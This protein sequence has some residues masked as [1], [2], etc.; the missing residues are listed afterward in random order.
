M[1]ALRPA[2]AALVCVLAAAATAPAAVAAPHIAKVRCYAGCISSRTVQPGGRVELVGK[3]FHTGMRAT[4]PVRTTDGSVA[5]RSTKTR[6]THSGDLIARVPSQGRSGRMFVRR[7]NGPRSNLVKVKVANPAA[8]PLP[9]TTAFDRDG[10]WI[11]YVKDASGGSA[12]AIIE[13]ARAHRIGTV[14]VKSG[15]DRNYW[16]QF[17]PKLVA[18]LKAGGLNVCG[19]QY[20]YGRH[21]KDEAKVA[22]RAIDAGADCFVIDAE[23]E[24]EGR[25]TQ[26]A[27]YVRRLRAAAGAAYP[28]ALASFPYVDYHPGFPYS[29][30]L[31][32]GGA[33]YNLPQAYWKDIGG[34]V[35]TILDHTYLWNRPYGAPVHPV[36]QLYQAPRRGEILRFRKFS[37]AAG[38]TGVSWW[39]WPEAS[40]SEWDAVGKELGPF[41]GTPQTEFA[42]LERGA[43]GD[44]VLWA[45]QHLAAAGE[46]LAV[47]GDFGGETTRAV[48]RFQ[49]RAALPVTGSI[50]SDTW[51]A[52][53]HAAPASDR[54]SKA[55]AT[56][57]VRPPTA[58]LPARR[59]E[60]PPAAERAP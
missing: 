8:D 20:V 57:A 55:A 13:Q 1:R 42:T 35:D 3:R 16:S 9:G 15:D 2:P 47:D 14:Y 43:R 6:L 22:A 32:P 49:A 40:G 7:P 11:W 48:K 21:P 52:L 54:R 39:S 41:K 37:K 25:Y 27:T 34:S 19:W 56:R 38:T 29:V 4:F 50:D 45:Q 53:L 44:I 28:I 58:D 31:G 51:T 23:I 46:D 5:L 18:A 59:Y 17:S 30:F 10:M 24:Y 12:N 36:G 33:Q 26:A 60:I